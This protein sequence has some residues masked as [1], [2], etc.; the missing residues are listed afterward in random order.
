MKP[1]RFTGKLYSTEHSQRY[2]VSDAEVR[3]DLGKEKPN[4][5]RLVINGISLTQWFR[6][7]YDEFREALGI[8]PKQIPKIVERKDFSRQIRLFAKSFVVLQSVKRPIFSARFLL[9]E[10]NLRRGHSF[11]II[12]I[13]NNMY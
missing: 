2:D 9:S 5:F 12:E 6:Q 11:L 7:K 4:G 3:F 10:E 8:K 13:G 1:V